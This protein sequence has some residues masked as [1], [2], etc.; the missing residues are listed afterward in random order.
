MRTTKRFAH[1]HSRR[2]LLV[3]ALLCA[4]AMALVLPATPAL[5][6]PVPHTKGIIP[7][8]NPRANISM[9]P[10]VCY[11][12]TAA[13]H[14]PNYP[15]RT[16]S[17]SCLDV[18]VAAISNARSLEGDVPPLYLP[19]NWASLTP[20][21]QLFVVLDSERVSRGLPPVA[22]I[23]ASLDAIARKS[24]GIFADDPTLPTNFSFGPRTSA[25]FLGS[26]WA[27]GES[28]PLSANYDWMYNDGWGGSLASTGNGACA[29]PH[30]PL[31][32]GHRDIVLGNYSDILDY[33]TGSTALLMGTGVAPATGGYAAIF[34]GV[35]GPSP[36]LIYTWSQAVAE[37]ALGPSFPVTASAISSAASGYDVARTNGSIAN[38]GTAPQFGDLTTAPSAPV[39]AMSGSKV[40]AGDYTATAEGN[41]YNFGFARFY[42]SLAGQHISSPVVGIAAAPLLHGYW[43]VTAEGRVYAFG[44][45]RSYGGLGARQRSSPAVAIAADSSGTGYL[46]VTADG[47]VYAFGSAHSHGGLGVRRRTSP[48]VGIAMDSSGTGYLLAT[49]SGS[50]FPFGSAHFHGSLDGRHLATPV[51]GVAAASSGSGYWLVQASGTATG[52]GGAKVF[53]FQGESPPSVLR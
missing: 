43:L 5:A 12:P 27:G 15:P 21:E 41:V 36:R 52:F 48:V 24:A 18:S 45:A 30:A 3:G 33:G 4:S 29:S 13:A 20:D 7:P 42:G 9:N 32:W 40:V 16:L 19:R 2:S 44:S 34:V 8:A 22:G 17:Q 6:G 53:H 46:I 23:A 26:I 47:K 50:V 1:G 49:S 37:G 14:F 28:S 39:V 38:Y 11:P 31:C 35:V 25:G 51:V 10:S